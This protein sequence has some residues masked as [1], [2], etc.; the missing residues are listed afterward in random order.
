V[1]CFAAQSEAAIQGEEA[2]ALRHCNIRGRSL[3]FIHLVT[4]QPMANIATLKAVESSR[5]WT[6]TQGAKATP[7]CTIEMNSRS[8]NVLFILE[9][10]QARK[11]EFGIRQKCSS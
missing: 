2:N 8:K 1:L 11:I 5:S 3:Q 9:F 7:L 10:D 4:A 6:S